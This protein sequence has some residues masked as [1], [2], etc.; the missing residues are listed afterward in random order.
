VLARRVLTKLPFSAAPGAMPPPDR[1]AWMLAILVP[2]AG[3]VLAHLAF[4]LHPAALAAGI[5]FYAW[6]SHAAWRALERIQPQ[7]R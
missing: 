5:A 4:A 7:R 1:V 6:R 3:L 2:V